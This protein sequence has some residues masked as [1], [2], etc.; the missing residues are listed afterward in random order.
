M[1]EGRKK[2]ETGAGVGGGVEERC[3]ESGGKKEESMREIHREQGNE[4]GEDRRSD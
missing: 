2:S 1:S 3:S 4:M